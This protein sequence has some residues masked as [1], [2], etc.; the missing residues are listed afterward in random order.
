MSSQNDGGQVFPD[1]MNSGMSLR[2]WFAGQVAAGMCANSAFAAEAKQMGLKD[3]KQLAI[4]YA[5]GAFNIAD[6]MLEARTEQS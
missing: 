6:A 2:D 1:A 4:R 3:T 5:I